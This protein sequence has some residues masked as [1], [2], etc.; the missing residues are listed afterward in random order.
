MLLINISCI[1]CIEE[2][3]KDGVVVGVVGDVS[4]EFDVVDDTGV[5]VSGVED[6]D[7]DA[8]GDIG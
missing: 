4:V 6:V 3:S 8:D 1:D 7:E 5:I 2:V